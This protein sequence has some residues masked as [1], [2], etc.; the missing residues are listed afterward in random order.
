MRTTLPGMLRPGR[1]SSSTCASWPTRSR[2]TSRS[3]TGT[4]T[5][6]TSIR[7]MVRMELLPES[8][9][10]RAPGSSRRTD[11]NPSRGDSMR[12]SPSRTASTPT[13]A[14]AAA[15]AASALS[16]AACCC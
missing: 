16:T 7:W 1:A 6:S 4:K 8:G 15:S 10:T 3:F 12:V 13:L 2:S 9:P 14:W 11:T 5:R